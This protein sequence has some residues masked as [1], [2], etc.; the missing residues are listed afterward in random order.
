MKCWTECLKEI[1]KETIKM[2]C[3]TMLEGN[4]KIGML[5]WNSKLKQGSE[6]L[7]RGME[8]EIE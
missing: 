5:E 6:L 3:H 1:M 8:Q 7:E 4:A 2:E